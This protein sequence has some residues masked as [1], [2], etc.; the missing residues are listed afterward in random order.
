M[1]GIKTKKN[2][3]EYSDE[4]RRRSL[5]IKDIKLKKAQAGVYLA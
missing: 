3:D 4:I 1:Q 2:Q 5:R